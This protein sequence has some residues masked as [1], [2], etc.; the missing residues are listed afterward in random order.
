MMGW[1]DTLDPSDIFF[2]LNTQQWGVALFLAERFSLYRDL[3][4]SSSRS[5]TGLALHV[6]N[7][8]P[9]IKGRSTLVWSFSRSRLRR[10]KQGG[11]SF[12]SFDSNLRSWPYGSVVE[13]A[14]LVQITK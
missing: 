14:S 9:M 1:D 4:P 10:G 2:T 5:D 11:V 13:I 8:R 12:R 7:G 3:R 6:A